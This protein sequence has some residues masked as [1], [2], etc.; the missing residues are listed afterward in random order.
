MEDKREAQAIKAIAAVIL[1]LAAVVLLIGAP[2]YFAITSPV[3]FLK[4]AG[5]STLGSLL[6]KI[7]LALSKD[8]E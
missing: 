2:I 7:G 1:L 5:V 6:G 3:L 8:L 4:V